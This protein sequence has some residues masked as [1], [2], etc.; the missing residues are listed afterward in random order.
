MFFKSNLIVSRIG[1]HF[2]VISHCPSHNLVSLLQCCL[3]VFY[4][5]FHNCGGMFDDSCVS[6]AACAD[7]VIRVFRLDDASNKSFK[8]V[9]LDIIAPVWLL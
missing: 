1:F 5:F 8:Y 9:V 7:G 2:C 6:P 4:F 3:N